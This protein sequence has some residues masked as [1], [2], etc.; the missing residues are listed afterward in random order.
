MHIRPNHHAR[1]AA[2]ARGV[3]IDSA[4]P[5]ELAELYEPRNVLSGYFDPAALAAELN[6][7]TKTLDRWRVIGEGPPSITVGRKRYYKRDA[8]IAWLETREERTK[9]KAA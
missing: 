8:V 1:R 6:V 9:R 5:D 2:A 4:T 7:C 3:D